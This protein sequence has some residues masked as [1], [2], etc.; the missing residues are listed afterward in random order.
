MTYPNESGRALLADVNRRKEFVMLRSAHAAAAEPAG[1][2]IIPYYALRRE[3]AKGRHLRF[4]SYQLFVDNFMTPDTPYSRL[5]VMHDMGTGKTMT[6]IGVALRFI[7]VFRLGV[8]R[9]I[10]PMTRPP[11]IWVVGYTPAAFKRDLF[12]FTELGFITRNEQDNLTKMR[13]LAQLGAEADIKAYKDYYSKLQRRLS[14]MRGNGFFKFIGF[15]ELTNRVFIGAGDLTGMSEAEITRGLASGAIAIN[16]PFVAQFENTLMIVDEVHNVYN[17]LM[18]NNWGRAIQVILNKF[19]PKVRGL[20]LSGTVLKNS[21]TEIVDVINLVAGS[22]EHMWSRADFFATDDSLLPGALNSITEI[23]AG[24]TS[25]LVDVNPQYYPR[26]T[27][28]GTAICDAKYLKFE[29][30]PMGRIQRSTYDTVAAD[31]ITLHEHGYIFDM[32]FPQNPSSAPSGSARVPHLLELKPEELHTPVKKNDE[33]P[34]EDTADAL[35]VDDEVGDV[36]GGVGGGAGDAGSANVVTGIFK[37]SGLRQ[38]ETSPP[39][40][41]A[42]LGLGVNMKEKT[43]YGEFLQR[44]R[45]A[46]Y[47]GKYPR[48]ID[49]L[50]E[51]MASGGGKV[52]IYHKFVHMTGVFLIGHIL[53]ANGF[54]AVGAPAGDETRCAL[55]G[56]TKKVHGDVTAAGHDHAPARYM[57]VHGELD[58]RVMTQ[59]LDKFNERDNTDGSRVMILVGSRV[60]KESHDLMATRHVFVVS[61]PDN[62]PSLL[63]ITARAIRAGSHQYL[64]P[65]KQDVTIHIFTAQLG[66][67]DAL[68]YEEDRY[69]RKVRDYGVIQQIERAIHAG[70]LDARINRRLIEPALVKDAIGHLWFEPMAIAADPSAAADNVDGLAL[71]DLNLSTFNLFHKER[72]VMDIIYVVKRLFMEWSKVWRDTDLWAAVQSPPFEF[73]YDTRLFGVDNFVVAM[74]RLIWNGEYFGEADAAATVADILWNPADKQLLLDG[75]T[76]GVIVRVGAGVGVGGAYFIAFPYDPTTHAPDIVADAP[77]RMMTPDVARSYSITSYIRTALSHQRYI[78]L[79]ESFMAQYRGKAI[80]EM[81]D[82]ICLHGH[83]FHVMLAE[84]IIAYMFNLWTDPKAL[85]SAEY[86][87]FYFQ[88]LYFYD[89]MGLVVWMNSAKPIVREM[90]ADYEKM[91]TEDRHTAHDALLPKEYVERNRSDL[92]SIA[93]DIERSG[94]SWCPNTT[95]TRYDAA[96]KRSKLRF[97]KLK[98]AT[99]EATDD[100]IPVGHTIGDVARFY[101]PERGWFSLPE[102]AKATASWHENEIV[103]G[104]DMR[105]AGGL[106]V[107]FRLRNPRQK[108]KHH[109]D[110]RLIERGII[111]TSRSKPYLFDLVKKLAITGIEK[112]ANLTVMCHEIRARLLYLELLERAKGSNIKWYYNQFEGGGAM[113]V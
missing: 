38:I 31:I 61:R 32:V 99:T 41:R 50:G 28:A 93:R 15:R 88:M 43:I 53:A 30:C 94:C 76:P 102:Y 81:T 55:C 74:H 89:A 83:D 26:H 90:Y 23:M 45:M 22:T 100:M 39:K 97:A 111:C 98:S 110:A 80:G 48:M 2:D 12:R 75:Q 82:A 4:K 58:K 103:V 25:F 60:L 1:S 35:P 19:G 72:E 65:E 92:I 7:E 63:Q 13:H 105:S 56:V 16:E 91:F 73:E 34:A 64:P 36:V 5:L 9:T 108:I 8:R 29:R 59:L 87:A 67:T 42:S 18:A 62:I 69:C 27:F 40:W 107:R 20:F 71:T 11:M 113:D 44:D 79:R 101:H 52:F 109:A 49:L 68:S 3:L 84:E 21:Q 14:N 57:L 104:F 24:R 86:N 37:V 96:L 112:N 47:S 66:G 78:D 106:H 85:A 17:S 77:F 54:V 33:G 51:I 10:T 46:E 70:A 6:A 95:K